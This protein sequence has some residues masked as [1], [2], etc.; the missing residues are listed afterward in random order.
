MNKQLKA[1]NEDRNKIG[2]NK[3]TQ[4]QHTFKV[5]KKN[6]KKKKKKRK[7]KEHINRSPKKY[8]YRSI[9]ILQ[10]EKKSHKKLYSKENENIAQSWEYIYSTEVNN[11]VSEHECQTCDEYVTIEELPLA[12]NKFKTPIKANEEMVSH[13][14]KKVLEIMKPYPCKDFLYKLRQ[15]KA[16]IFPKTKYS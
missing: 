16:T 8:C 2:K 6:Q 15:A 11:N 5:W 9:K 3:A 7:K 12:V 1:P 14:Y 4:I 13:L 10:I